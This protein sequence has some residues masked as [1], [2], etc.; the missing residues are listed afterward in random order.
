MALSTTPTNTSPNP[1][2]YFVGRGQVFWKND[3]VGGSGAWRDLGNAPSVQFKAAI[4]NLDHFS[5][6]IGL[7][8][9]D[10]SI[11]IDANATLIVKLD[12]WTGDN[13][14]LAIMGLEGTS[15]DI[16]SESSITGGFFFLG[17]NDIGAKFSALFP[18][19]NLTP[20]GTL[21]FIGSSDKY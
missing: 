15:F 6:R 8:L 18:I 17:T 4:K 2:N 21:D 20:T 10:R 14:A 7:K 5:S 19:V 16:L 12:E 11:A 1:L 9:K 13:L 3:S